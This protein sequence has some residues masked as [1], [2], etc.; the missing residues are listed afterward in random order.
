MATGDTDPKVNAFPLMV[1]RG[2]IRRASFWR[3]QVQE[4]KRRWKGKLFDC[5]VSSSFLVGAHRK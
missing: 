2:Q 4:K 1:K 3:G 5:S